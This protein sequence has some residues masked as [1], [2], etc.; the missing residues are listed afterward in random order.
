MDHARSLGPTSAPVPPAYSPQLN[1]A[2]WAVACLLSGHRNTAAAC[3]YHRA[4]LAELRK[5]G[6]PQLVCT[7]AP[8][9]KSAPSFYA[10]TKGLSHCEKTV[11][12]R[13][14]AMEVFMFHL[15]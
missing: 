12:L 13:W 1:A 6:R 8:D 5:S 4:R 3:L 2:Q 10:E 14:L 7:M 11:A 9:Q 15:I